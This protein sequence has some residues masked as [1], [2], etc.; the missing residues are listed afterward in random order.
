[1]PVP[2]LAV[3]AG[4]GTNGEGPEFE[5]G[6]RLRLP[7]SKLSY[8]TVGS[9]W[10]TAHYTG[11]DGNGLA[12]FNRIFEGIGENTRSYA[13][14]EHAHFW[15]NELGAESRYRHLLARYYVGYAALLNRSSYACT[16]GY[17][18]CQPKAS[19]MILYAGVALGYVF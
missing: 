11:H 12:G 16:E 6:L 7:L 15:N 13:V 3:Q 2:L 9:G 17:W 8:F 18:P 10:S 19:N 1:M 14:W 5:A 4:V